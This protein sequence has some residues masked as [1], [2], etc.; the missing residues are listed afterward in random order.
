MLDFDIDFLDEKK[1]FEHPGI[2]HSLF[3]N[4]PPYIR[5]SYA[6]IKPFP[7]PI[8]SLI[9]WKNSSIT[10]EIVRRVVRSTGFRLLDEC[11][12]WS[13]LW[14]NQ[15]RN[16]DYPKLHEHQ[17]FNHFPST[18][19]VGR[20]DS[21]WKN[22]K[23]MKQRY[24][25]RKFD[26]APP[27]F[28]LPEEKK[29]FRM[30]WENGAKD[31]CYILKP[32]ASYR[33]EGIKIVSKLKQIPK[34]ENYVAQKYIHD[35]YLI[36][37]TKFDMRLYVL[38]TSI[39][40]LRV[41]LYDNGLARFASV[42]YS[43]NFRNLDNHFMHLTNYSINKE[44]KKYQANSDVHARKG[45]KWTLNTLWKYLDEQNI[46]TGKLKEDLIELVVKTMISVEE[47]ISKS[48]SQNLKSRYNAFELFGFDVLL[49]KNL[50]P[51]LLEVNISPS[52]HSSSKLDIAVKVPLVLNVLNIVGFHI[53]VSKKYSEK[54]VALDLGASTNDRIWLDSR[55]YS[56]T[57]SNHEKYKHYSFAEPKRRNDYLNKILEDLTPE[58]VR[59]LIAY[60]DE[61]TQIGSF[62]KVFPTP[63]S[64]KYFKYFKKVS[65]YNLLLDAW[66]TKYHIDREEGRNLLKTYCEKEQH[67]KVARVNSAPHV[68]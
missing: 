28:V 66:E 48:A 18:Y 8:Q 31:Q 61:L 45:H 3:P 37:D 38:I 17:K 59:I 64:H 4:V 51:W 6:P 30:Q 47:P 67:L 33:G 42:K 36:N 26:I 9:R 19:H 29:T 23:Q 12:C 55:I 63:D 1:E 25:D 56:V 22:I 21:L 43:F 60:E 52:L 16:T 24:G 65:Y 40:P 44:N 62:I 10:P 20:K 46:D 35:P 14:G 41:Y 58:D 50:K 53:P 49:D 11:R 32:P 57:V 27:S 54:E 39:D 68:F 2:R 5:F 13:G 7:L 34:N 15:M